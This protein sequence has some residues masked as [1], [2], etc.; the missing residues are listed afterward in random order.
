MPLVRALVHDRDALMSRV[1]S[2]FMP[3]VA[4]RYA[5]GRRAIVVLP[6]PANLL[7]R[8]FGGVMTA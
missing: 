4:S 8:A 7:Q 6:P 1:M 2:V 5:A 3:A